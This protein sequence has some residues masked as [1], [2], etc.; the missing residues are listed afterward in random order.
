M[1]ITKRPSGFPVGLELVTEVTSFGT[2]ATR[3]EDTSHVQHIVHSTRQEHNIWCSFFFS[4]IPGFFRIIRPHSPCWHPAA[5]RKLE[6]HCRLTA[7]LDTNPVI[8][9]NR[10]S[11]LPPAG[12]WLILEPSRH[13]M[14]KAVKEPAISRWLGGSGIIPRLGLAPR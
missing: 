8:G 2:P 12:G 3:R 6:R 10:T 11:A 9:T 13:Q 14:R 1:A 4:A 7:E 5:A